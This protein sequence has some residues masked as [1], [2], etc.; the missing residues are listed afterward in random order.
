MIP[1]I[2]SIDPGKTS[3]LSI[4]T[5]KAFPLLLAHRVVR[6]DGMESC[7]WHVTNMLNQRIPEMIDVQVLYA[8]IED[9]YLA[10][11]KKKNPNTL[12]KLSRVAG[13]WQEGCIFAGLEVRFLYASVWQKAELGM[14][15]ASRDQRKR[16]SKSKAFG[17]WKIELTEDE[18]DSAIMGR[19][20]ALKQFY[21]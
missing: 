20:A 17:L 3:G 7:S 9:Q 13:R 4:V 21:L 14:V 5:I 18:S 15:T 6:F 19:Y 12:K 8:V 2:L 1:A 11:G 16:A 10:T